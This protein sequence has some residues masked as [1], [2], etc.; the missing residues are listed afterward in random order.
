MIKKS[1]IKIEIDIGYNPVDLNL[2]LEQPLNQLLSEADCGLVLGGLTR[3]KRDETGKPRLGKSILDV[4]LTKP[5]KGLSIIE[6]FLAA[7]ELKEFSQIIEEE[8]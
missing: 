8:R 1:I 5:E 3:V 2:L 4:V 7:K 6:E